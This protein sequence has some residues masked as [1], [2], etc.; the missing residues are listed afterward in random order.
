MPNEFEE[1][2]KVDAEEVEGT[3]AEATETNMEAETKPEETK[4]ER[5]TESL[6]DR[7]AR[8]LRQL[9]QT[10]KKL[11]IEIEK[12]EKKTSKRSDDFD[13]GAKA[14]LVANGVK[15]AREIQLAKDFMSNTGKSLD[16]IL[17]NK[18]FQ[19]ELK[20]LRDLETT[21][22][23]TPKG[24]RSGSPAVDSVEYWMAK[25]IE[26]VPKDMQIKVVNARLKKDEQKGAFYNQ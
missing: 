12:P 21:T 10:N 6:E 8:L 1:E 11:G 18:Y 22:N 3:E 20:D 16:D 5:P 17:E 26:E 9:E 2:V 24:S 7:R 23:A 19:A 14:F 25:P 15:G 4:V 13:Y